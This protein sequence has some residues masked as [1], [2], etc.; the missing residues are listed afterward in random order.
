MFWHVPKAPPKNGSVYSLRIDVD[1]A[2]T[3]L[4]DGVSGRGCLVSQACQM[5]HLEM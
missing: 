4:Q 1:A 3:G 2:G 5:C